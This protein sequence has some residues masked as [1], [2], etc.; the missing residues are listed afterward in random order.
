[1][2]RYFEDAAA[3][4]EVAAAKQARKNGDGE[5]GTQLL[6]R[7]ERPSAE[8]AM[9]HPFFSVDPAEVAAMVAEQQKTIVRRS[10]GGLFGG[11][12][13]GGGA[14]AK[15]KKAKAKAKAKAEAKAKKSAD[16]DDEGVADA[17]DEDEDDEDDGLLEEEEE[18]LSAMGDVLN[19]M[20]GLEKRISKQQDLIAQQSTTIMRL[21]D[22]GAP[23]AVVEKEQRTLEK[24]RVGLQ[25]LLRSFSFSQVEAKTTMVKAATE[26]Q[27][28]AADAGVETG[29]LKVWLGL[30]GGGFLSRV[31]PRELKA[32]TSKRG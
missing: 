15:E 7:G 16:E 1:L 32:P 30:G 25:G 28:E 17:E 9:R 20:L 2:C 11:F 23:E 29:P 4:A 12:F 27:K 26:M 8:E 5:G 21:R 6:D 19:N 22:E 14:K 13:G 24:M 18:G 3:A 10:S 31:G